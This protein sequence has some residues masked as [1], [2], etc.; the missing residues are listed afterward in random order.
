MRIV[1]NTNDRIRKL[2]SV[3]NMFGPPDSIAAQLERYAN[4]MGNEFY[5]ASKI[6]AELHRL[7]NRRTRDKKSI[8]ARLLD[9]S[10]SETEKESRFSKLINLLDSLKIPM[11]D[12]NGNEFRKMKD[13]L[14]RDVLHYE[15]R[16]RSLIRSAFGFELPDRIN[17][18]LDYALE[19][20]G[21]GGSS[22]SY[23]PP[24]IS[25]QLNR[26]GK[27]AIGVMV[28]ELLHSLIKKY[29]PLDETDR[30]VHTK[31][32]EALLDYFAPDGIIDYRLGLIKK[33]NLEEIEKI[34]GR[35]RPRAKEAS[36]RLLP[37]IREYNDIFGERTVWSFLKEKGFKEIR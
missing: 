34:N 27:G 21:S 22:V 23:T 8:W 18:V 7:W 2:V 28:H 10:V 26:Y 11:E 36:E 35:Q 16:T 33:L 17:I 24:I 20:H 5:T 9:N 1:F 31:F 29:R 3:W 4:F 19:V 14:R 12:A 37:Y 13:S 25:L 32:E 6:N 15:G 30:D